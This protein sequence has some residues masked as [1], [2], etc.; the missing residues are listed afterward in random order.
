VGT[1]GDGAAG[2]GV[3]ERAGGGVGVGE[4][5][6]EGP[7]EGGDRG[8]HVASHRGGGGGGGESPESGN[9]GMICSVVVQ[10]SVEGKLGNGF[11]RRS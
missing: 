2:E 9:W 3:G 8:L 5:V 10:I 11:R 6:G 1:E 4:H 7:A